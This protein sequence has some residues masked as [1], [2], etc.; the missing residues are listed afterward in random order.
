[1]STTVDPR[2]T[3]YLNRLRERASVLPPDEF[4]DVWQSVH[5]HLDEAAERGEPIE[6]ALARLGSPEA[7]VAAA[8]GQ[9]SAQPTRPVQ[10]QRPLR[11][12]DVAALV[13]LQ[14]GA[15]VFGLGWI[16]GVLLLWVS[17]RWKWW[18][19]LL[20]TLVVPGGLSGLVMLSGLFSW[21][22]TGCSSDAVTVAETSCTATGS[23][24]TVIGPIVVGLL[25]AGAIA[26]TV[27][28]ARA[29]RPGR[30]GQPA[31]GPDPVERGA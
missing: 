3:D 11:G 6:Q 15:V 7:I 23:A 10:P 30:S 18:E 16:A 27:Y 2:V 31:S 8:A 12:V 26:V 24:S 13:L 29:A 5:E 22:S 25:A 21:A 4:E 28:L 14:V 17:D 20:G 9:P 1:M 19:K